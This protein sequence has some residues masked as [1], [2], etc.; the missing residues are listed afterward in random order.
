V[1]HFVTDPADPRLHDY[2]DIKDARVAGHGKGGKFV[3][4]SE[5]VV[6]RLL[7]SGLRVDS[8]LLTA[9]RLT[10]LEAVLPSE[11]PIYVVAQEVMDGVAGLPVHRG[12]LAVGERPAD[13]HV[14]EGVRRVVVLEDLVDVDNVGALVR[15]AAAFGVDALLLSPRCADPY[16]RKAIRVSAGAVFALP[17]VRAERWPTDLV[18]LRDHHGL[19]LLGAA[20]DAEATP[21]HT[22]IPP[23]RYALVLGAEGPGLALETKRLC[24]ALITIPMVNA[25]SLNVATAG[26]VILDGLRSPRPDRQDA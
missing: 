14:P 17:I 10:A 16:Y 21:L 15:N 11:V 13:A 24:D 12:C 5:V 4:E 9:P 2:R 26:A 23:A 19:A 7:A 1:I 6:R 18:A 8:V 3:A 25:D 22:F 20:L